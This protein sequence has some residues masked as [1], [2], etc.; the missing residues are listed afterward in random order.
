M[1]ANSTRTA[2][3]LRIFCA[4]LLLSL[5]FAHKPVYA[6][7]AF[8]PTS[9]YYALPDGGFA[10]LCGDTDQG[11]PGKSRLGCEACRLASNVLLPAPPA[12]HACAAQDFRGIEFSLRTAFLCSALPRPG[13]PVRGP[14]SLIA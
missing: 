9:S 14:P 1:T 10:D 11:K 5:G 12:D 8:N 13:S 7:P 4:A 6:A 3:W 2:I